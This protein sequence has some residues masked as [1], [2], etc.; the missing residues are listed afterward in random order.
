[1]KG[2]KWLTGT[3]VCFAVIKNKNKCENYVMWQSWYLDK[4]DG[5]SAVEFWMCPSSGNIHGLFQGSLHKHGPLFS[6]PA[7]VLFL[8][9][10]VLFLS[11]TRSQH[12]VF[13][14]FIDCAYLLNKHGTFSLDKIPKYYGEWT[15]ACKVI[16]SQKKSP[17]IT[18]HVTLP[19]EVSYLT[20]FFVKE[21]RAFTSWMQNET[22]RIQ[23]I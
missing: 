20:D 21:K 15:D 9:C 2:T 11:T 5:H 16:K 1:M 6:P 23:I 19:W 13:F 8:L 14:S 10:F 12:V 3:Q 7:I 4:S 17:L 18:T 22:G